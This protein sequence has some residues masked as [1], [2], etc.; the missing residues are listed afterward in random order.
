MYTQQEGPAPKRD[1]G[2]GRGCSAFVPVLFPFC[3]TSTTL[4]S[5]GTG[6][7]L[8]FLAVLIDT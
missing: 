3:P 2:G 7:A 6:K 1:G 5:A 8:I 4:G